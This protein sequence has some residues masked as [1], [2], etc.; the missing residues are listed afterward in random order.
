MAFG[1][2]GAD[3]YGPSLELTEMWPQ[4]VEGP[5][6]YITSCHSLLGP[7]TKKKGLVRIGSLCIIME[8]GM[9]HWKLDK[10]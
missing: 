8:P 5:H 10:I 4:L 1:E 6:A 3:L 7:G 9:E 2:V